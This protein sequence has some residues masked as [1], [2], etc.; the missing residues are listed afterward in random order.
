MYFCEHA[1]G[2]RV[3]GLPLSYPSAPH[4]PTDDQDFDSMDT[5][6]IRQRAYQGY[7]KRSGDEEGQ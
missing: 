6:R 4:R 7:D 2:G 5:F 3:R 1:Y